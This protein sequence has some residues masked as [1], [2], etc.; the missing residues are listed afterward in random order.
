[1]QVIETAMSRSRT[2]LLSLAVI[3][4]AGIVAY[5]TLPKEAEPDIEIPMIYVHITHDGISPED[6]ERLLVRPM[7]Q[8]LRTIEGI[9]EMT[10]NAYEGG[11]NVLIEFDAGIDTDKALADVREKVD[12]AKAKLPNETDEPT[13]NEVNLSLFPVLVVT[14]SGD[15]PE[16]TLVRLARDLRDELSRI[17]LRSRI[18]IHTG[19]AERRGDDLGGVAVHLAARVLAEGRERLA[20]FTDRPVELADLPGPRFMLGAIGNAHATS[21][22]F[23]TPAKR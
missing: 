23:K 7:E 20:E 19:E 14:L 2:V 6:G 17:G 10:A 15:V 11:A 8:E 21:Q 13:V 3:L 4:V 1:M 12:M 18:A 9:K 5:V 16:R 22:P